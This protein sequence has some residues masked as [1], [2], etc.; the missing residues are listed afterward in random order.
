MA[1]RNGEK[2]RK[3]ETRQK[4]NETEVKFYCIILLVTKYYISFPDRKTPKMDES[5]HI[6]SRRLLA[7]KG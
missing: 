7:T 1:G 3:K 2:G 4:K 5:V 6:A